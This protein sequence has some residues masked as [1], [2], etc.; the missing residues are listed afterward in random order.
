MSPSAFNKINFSFFSATPTLSFQILNCFFPL[1][2]SFIV[3][4]DKKLIIMFEKLFPKE[5][6]SAIFKRHYSPSKN[7]QIL[8]METKV[9]S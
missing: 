5:V 3:S 7:P 8:K 9:S 2:S 1:F 4:R 6:F